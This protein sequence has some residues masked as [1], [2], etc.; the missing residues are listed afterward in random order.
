MEPDRAHQ[1]LTVARPP[2][3]R[4]EAEIVAELI[5]GAANK[6]IAARFGVSDQTVK[7]QLSTLYRKLHV[8]GRLE[9]VVLMMKRDRDFR[10][11]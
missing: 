11:D 9:L 4:R 10:R 3:T 6:E 7:N 1:S 8:G 2:L 5:E